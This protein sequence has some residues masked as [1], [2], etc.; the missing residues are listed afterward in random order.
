MK[1][2]SPGI[3]L[4]NSRFRRLHVL[5]LSGSSGPSQSD[6]VAV[7]VWFCCVILVRSSRTS[8]E[9][10]FSRSGG[11]NSLELRGDISVWMSF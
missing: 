7:V 4:W 9:L 2:K 8:T 11:W 1:L 3:M 5:G 10:V 6:T